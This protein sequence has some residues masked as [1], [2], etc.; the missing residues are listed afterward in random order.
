MIS[1]IIRGKDECHW[2]KRL[3]PILKS[4]TIDFELIYVDNASSDDSVSFVQQQWPDAIIRTISHFTPGKALN[5]GI[6]ASNGTTV[7]FLS[8][9]CLPLKTDWL[10]VLVKPIQEGRAKITYGRQVP[11]GDVGDLSIK[12]E[13]RYTFKLDSVLQEK[14]YFFHNANSAVSKELLDEMPFNEELSHVEDLVWAKDMITN[15]ECIF[16]NADATVNHYHGIGH[17]HNLSR[18]QTIN[19]I[20]DALDPNNHDSREIF[21]NRSLS[22]LFIVDRANLKTASAKQLVQQ[23]DLKAECIS[24]IKGSTLEVNQESILNTLTKIAVGAPTNSAI[25]YFNSTHR[26][27]QMNRL[28]EL[29]NKYVEGGMDSMFFG[30][31]TYENIFEET[32]YGLRAVDLDLQPRERKHPKIISYFGAGLLVNTKLILEGK[33]IDRLSCVINIK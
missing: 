23:S 11:L 16:Y 5:I 6:K 28:T 14:D 2:L 13:L 32:P 26:D 21:R 31:R 25:L 30:E 20:I 15:G 33:L 1:L 9:H 8:C 12:R 19:K 3:I 7:A 10:E 22:N 17:G 27:F 24:E 29:V 4:Q 18:F